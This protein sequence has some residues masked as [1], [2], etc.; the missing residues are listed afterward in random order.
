MNFGV[1]EFVVMIM[2]DVGGIRNPPWC[3]AGVLLCVYIRMYLVRFI[4]SLG[5]FSPAFFR[6]V[7]KVMSLKPI[8]SM[9]IMCPSLEMSMFNMGHRCFVM[10]WE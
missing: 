5:A 8:V 3:A 6:I 7:P 4:V 2:L 9:P 1:V 10:V